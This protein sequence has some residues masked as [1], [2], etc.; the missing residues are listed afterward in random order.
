ML[1]IHVLSLKADQ[2]HE[3]TIV[4]ILKKSTYF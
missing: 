3:K 4:K 1:F 2:M